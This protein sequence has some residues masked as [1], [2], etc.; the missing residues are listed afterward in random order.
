MLLPPCQLYKCFNSLYSHAIH[1]LLRDDRYA[2]Y[3]NPH[4]T[5]TKFRTE[6]AQHASMQHPLQF[7]RKEA[8]NGAKGPPGGC[9]IFTR[10]PII[11]MN[12]GTRS[13][14][15]EVTLVVPAAGRSSR[16][17]GHKP[18]W[19]LT[20]PN[21]CLM[22]VDALGALNM[23]QVARVVVGILRDHLDRFCGGDV[24][25][26]LKAFDDGHKELQQIPVSIVVIPEETK[27]QVQTLECILHTAAI[28]GPIFLKDCD[29]QFACPVKAIDGVATQEI[30]GNIQSVSIPAAKSYITQTPNGLITNIAEKVILSNTFCIGGYSF[31]SASCT[32]FSIA[33]ARSYQMLTSSTNVE[34]SVSD[35]VWIKMLMEQVR[36]PHSY[37]MYQTLM[38]NFSRP[39]S[40]PSRLA[41][42]RIGAL[43]ML[44]KPTPEPGKHSSWTSMAHSSRIRASILNQGGQKA[45]GRYFHG[46]SS[47]YGLCTLAVAHRSC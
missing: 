17:P 35:I 21:G 1:V 7:L 28:T 3:L 31:R 2:H 8:L 33:T 42:T 10:P 25:A 30:T 24:N 46:M 11:H 20:Q 41:P 36:F 47:I 9:E 19:L 23:T 32:I 16:F 15:R 18:K 43:W 27:D 22:V 12:G 40:S 45:R 39:H 44:G 5:D 4:Q 38:F 26:L 13:G 6:R 37:H 34:L 29:N 14:N